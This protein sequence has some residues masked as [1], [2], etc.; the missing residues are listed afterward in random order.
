[1]ILTIP[2]PAMNL[3]SIEME[4]SLFVFI[5]FYVLMGLFTAIASIRLNIFEIRKEDFIVLFGTFIIWPPIIFLLLWALDDFSNRL[6]KDIEELK[7]QRNNVQ[8]I[9]EKGLKGQKHGKQ[10]NKD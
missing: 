1:M 7:E 9:L 8:K 10:K 4:L 5:V 6:E 3:F 2:Y